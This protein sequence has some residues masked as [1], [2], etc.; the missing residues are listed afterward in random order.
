MLRFLAD[1]IEDLPLMQAGSVG[2]EIIVP[3]IHTMIIL[4][5]CM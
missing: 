5:K 2:I 4:S 3:A 1:K